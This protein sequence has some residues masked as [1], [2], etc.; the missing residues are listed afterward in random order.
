MSDCCHAGANRKP[1]APM[2]RGREFF[3]WLLPSAVL[4]L[5]PKCP[6]CLAAYV[7]LFSGV[8]LSVS[9]AAWLRWALLFICVAS[10]IFLV[11]KR[12]NRL[13]QFYGY[14]TRRRLN[15]GTPNN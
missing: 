8:G 1:A 15:H 7:A 5:M 4:V 13:R 14:F 3:K 12:L 2:R 9:T 10:L 6:V 11:A